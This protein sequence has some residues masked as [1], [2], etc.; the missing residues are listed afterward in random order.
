MTLG[1]AAKSAH[2]PYCNGGIYLLSSFLFSVASE[3]DLTSASAAPAGGRRLHAV[4]MRHLRQVNDRTK[5]CAVES[6]LEAIDKHRKSQLARAMAGR[7][8]FDLERV[9]Q[10]VRSPLNLI[11]RRKDH[12]TCQGL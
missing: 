7:H 6:I 3:C 5:A 1:K 8:P 10:Y 2:V 4:V 11:L 12:G 9:V